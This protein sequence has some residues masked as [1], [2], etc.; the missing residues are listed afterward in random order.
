MQQGSRVWHLLYFDSFCSI[1]ISWNR[2]TAVDGNYQIGVYTLK[3]IA[4]G[5]EITFDY[6]SVT[7][8]CVFCIKT[9]CLT[10]FTLNIFA[11]FLQSKDEYEASVCLC[12]SQVCRGSFLNLTGEEA[13][14][15]V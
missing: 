6:N 11:I 5:E 15:N 12:G 14:Q 3:P 7:E 2:V 13:Y 1:C 4:Y 8:V 9:S 10:T